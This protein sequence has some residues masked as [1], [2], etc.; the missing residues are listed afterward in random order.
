[1]PRTPT[2]PA[3]VLKSPVVRVAPPPDKKDAILEAALDLFSERGFYGTSVPDIA[4]RAKVGAGTIYRYF[5]SKEALVNILYQHHK[6]ELADAM[7]RELDVEA[8][9]RTIFHEFWQRVCRFAMKNPKAVQFLEL[10]HHARYL[11][12]TS[13]KMESDLLT[14]AYGFLNDGATKEVFKNLPPPL[15]LA[16]VWGGF[17]GVFQGGCD[18]ILTLDETTI[19]QAEQCIWEAIRR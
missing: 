18:G 8:P 9:P 17:R 6:A 16:I 12:E 1:M 3:A 19:T 14:I 7:L 4:A 11:D 13:R 2:S 10:H 5:E 15:L